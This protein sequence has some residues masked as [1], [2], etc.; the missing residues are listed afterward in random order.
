MCTICNETSASL[1]TRRKPPFVPIIQNEVLAVRNCTPPDLA[2]N[3]SDNSSE[4]NATREKAKKSWIGYDY[5]FWP[6]INQELKLE[7]VT[8]AVADKVLNSDN[9]DHCLF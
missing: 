4:A 6:M 3:F 7:D 9:T 1:Y 8:T 5:Y 2:G